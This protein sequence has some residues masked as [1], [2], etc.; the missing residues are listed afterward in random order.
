MY[1]SQPAEP[2]E[3]SVSL[4]SAQQSNRSSEKISSSN[5]DDGAAPTGTSFKPSSRTRPKDGAR[6][7]LDAFTA[8]QRRTARLVWSSITL[9]FNDLFST[10]MSHLSHQTATAVSSPNPEHQQS[11]QHPQTPDRRSFNRSSKPSRKIPP[12]SEFCRNTHGSGLVNGYA[13]TER[14]NSSEGEHRYQ[15][16]SGPRAQDSLSY[17]KKTDNPGDQINK[18]AGSVKQPSS[19]LFDPRAKAYSHPR[20]QH[21]KQWQNVLVN[22]SPIS[23]DTV[24]YGKKPKRTPTRGSAGEARQL[25]DPRK[26]DPMKFSASKRNGESE[27]QPVMLLNP[28]SDTQSEAIRKRLHDHDQNANSHQAFVDGGKTNLLSRLKHSYKQIV[29]LETILKDEEHAAKAKEEELKARE[30]R[31][32]QKTSQSHSF[33]NSVALLRLNAKQKRIDEEYWVRLAK[34]HRDIPQR[35]WQTAFHQ[36]LERLRHEAIPQFSSA[37]DSE[38][39]KQHL[40]DHLT[41]FIYFAYGFYTA[42]LDEQRLLPFKSV[43][44]EQLGDLA[45]YRMAVAGMMS[46]KVVNKTSNPNVTDKTLVDENKNHK[47]ISPINITKA[48]RAS[49]RRKPRSSPVGSLDEDTEQEAISCGSPSS[50][51]FIGTISA[52]RSHS[53][54]PHNAKFQEPAASIGLAALGN[55]DFEEQEIWR[56]TA[57]DW[58]SKGLVET[59]GSGRLHHHLALL[60]KGDELR[61]LYHYCKSLTAASPYLPAR[62]SILPFFESEHQSRRSRPE[63]SISDL[64]VHLHGMLFTKI[65]LDDFEKELARFMERLAE[66]R[67]LSA[68]Q[69]QADFEERRHRSTVSLNSTMPDVSWIMM[70]VINICALLQYGAEDGVIK[71]DHQKNF[72]PSQ[73]FLRRPFTQDLQDLVPSSVEFLNDKPLSSSLDNQFKG[74]VIKIPD[75]DESTN[76][77]Q[78]AV[79]TLAAKLS[80]SM[81]EDVLQHTHR[82]QLCPY[83]TLILTFIA[84]MTQ[85]EGLIKRFERFIPWVKLAE[86]FNQL[87]E[88]VFLKLSSHLPES[89]H[90]TNQSGMKFRLTGFP[91]LEDWCLRGMEWTG[92]NLFGRGFWKSQKNHG[93]ATPVEH[94]V[95]LKLPYGNFNIESEVDVLAGL[96]EEHEINN[97]QPDEMNSRRKRVGLVAFWFAKLESWLIFEDIPDCDN[98]FRIS[99]SLKQKLKLWQEEA[100][101]EREKQRLHQQQ[102]SSRNREI[103]EIDE[104]IDRGIGDEDEEVEEDDPDESDLIKSLKAR[105]RELRNMLRHGSNGA[106]RNPAPLPQKAKAKLKASQLKPA[107]KKPQINAAPG[108]TV[109]VFDTN[110]LIGML[111]IVKGLLELEQFTIIIPLVVVTELDGLKKGNP[112]DAH[113]NRLANEAGEAIKFLE[114]S[115]KTKSKWLKIQTSRG[116]YLRDLLVRRE[117]IKLHDDLSHESDKFISTNAAWNLDDIVLQATIWQLEH[118]SSRLNVTEPSAEPPEKVVLVT[119][120]RNLRLKARVRGIVPADERGIV[121]LF[122]ALKPKGSVKSKG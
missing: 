43:W 74:I 118:F 28:D 72:K 3:Q 104:E 62:E 16:R 98:K 94:G 102:K 36:L 115:V 34:Q 8:Y 121:S 91:L 24:D 111:S 66:D 61:T 105:R 113:A 50:P 107:S 51:S 47:V 60:S 37:R 9:I 97:V 33:T 81:L 18:S 109:L 80:F 63:V 75:L 122:S 87:P 96:S 19:K 10:P 35:L 82:E 110:I 79:F 26:H 90:S 29:S 101:F 100:Q 86:F 20:D 1:K 38:P 88:S 12:G 5:D 120:D 52:S 55:W 14:N 53:P 31:E 54:S 92:K 70:A 30:A 108:Y 23:F 45:R 4:V 6:T 119:M 76:K 78:P 117:E 99:D 13:D 67:L 64:F 22:V 89:T 85:N 84:S 106:S 32:N 11:N 44:I 59:P 17:S 40:L 103:A 83:A 15:D 48:K 116:N 73:D 68:K 77:E 95:Q 25:F 58:Y 2:A 46:R 65:Q 114:G 39:S 27:P 56:S 112:D 93:N 7:I 21:G 41:D 57:K 49:R 42:L 71:V 69:H